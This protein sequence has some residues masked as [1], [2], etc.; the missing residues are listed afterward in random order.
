MR[1]RLTASISALLCLAVSAAGQGEVRDFATAVELSPQ[2]QSVNPAWLSTIGEGSF[3]TARTS[4]SKHDG[5]LV[6]LESSPDAWTAG[7]STESFSR[8]SGKLSFYGKMAYTYQT[9][10]K[11]GGQILMAPRDNPINFLE[12]DL[13]SAGRRKKESYNLA[14]KLCWTFSDRLSA[15]AAFDYGASDRTKFR[16]PRFA[17]VL[18]ELSLSPGLAFRISGDF[19]LGVN[20]SWK[21]S[22]EQLSANTYG[23]IDKQ[24]Y[25]LVDQGG[26]FGNREEFTGDI[27]YVSLSNARPM[28][29][30]RF[31]LSV[32]SLS[33]H[34]ARLFNRLDA[35]WRTG[36]YGNKSSSSVVFCEFKGP[37]MKY[38][39]ELALV[40]GKDRHSFKLEAEAKMLSNF[41]NSYK[42]TVV[43]GMT[44]KIEYNGQNE[45]LSRNDADAILAYRFCKGM[46]G[47]RPDWIF[48]AS[49]SAFMRNQTTTIYPAYRNH[50]FS[51]FTFS[52]GAERN[53]KTS[54]DCFTARLGAAFTAGGGT[55][56][57]D[58]TLASGSSKARS[59]DDWLYRQ[60]EYGTAARAAVSIDLAWTILRYRKLAPYI[61]LSDSF[62]S[63]LAEPRYLDGK[64]RNVAS[65]SLGCNF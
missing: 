19:T 34:R 9:E 51:N 62:V 47:Y 64:T 50:S 24:Y 2:L 63:L 28:A 56:A 21:H 46:D 33:G 54:R 12:E 41:T 49:A 23:T 26:F 57:D 61:K 4:F 8:I 14:G 35:F 16:D 36:F 5:D 42:Y 25:I 27:G 6:P 30:N 65:V 3:S 40:F 7:L 44:T 11:S 17:D 22:L 31:G 55:A 38:A 45:T 1:F 48:D 29:D 43:P 15:G 37:E 18:M 32:Q 59:F 52:A 53:L 20:L 10:E 13:S 60:F 39:G 58:G